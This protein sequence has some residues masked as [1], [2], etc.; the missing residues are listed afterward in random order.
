MHSFFNPKSVAV[1]GASREENKLGHIIFRNFFENGFRK[2]YP[3]NPNAEEILGVKCYKSILDVKEKIDLAIIVVPAKIVPQVLTECVKKKTP[4][5]IIISSGFSE[6]G[7]E[8]KK[9]EEQLKQIIAKSGTRVIGPNCI[10]IYD[11]YSRVDTLFLSKDRCGRPGKG[12]IS[13]IS[14]SGAVGSTI[15]DI[16][17]SSGI[18]ISKFISYGNGMDVS[19]AE[20]LEYLGKDKTTKVII[21]YIEGLKSDGRKFLE[22]AKKAKKPIIVLKSG[23]GEKGAKA[24][25]SH[26]G[27]L[28]G[29]RK[30][31][32]AA[33]KQ[34]GIIEADDWEELLDYSVAFST[35]PKPRG[36]RV[37]IITDGGGFGV[38]AAD[39][40]EELGLLLPEPSQKLKE[41]LSKRMPNYVSLHNPIDLTG[42]A[43][44]ERY[45]IA[46]NECLS[47]K[48]YDGAIVIT[49]FQVPTLEEKVVDYII[50]ARKFKK[51]LLVCSVGSNFTQ[52]RNQKLIK[53]GIPVYP[54][55]ERAVKAFHA[56]TKA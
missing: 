32:S 22:K 42:D 14:Q 24:V 49:L 12:N 10:G 3:I 18:G 29:E 35:Q 39:K 31:Y 47:S 30:I 48:E 2:L 37:V 16:F 6:I 23:K 8:G 1:I 34:F 4:S 28:A 25:S 40:A 9:I 7:D 13:F 43:N 15:L 38:L 46:L 50:E 21:A 27:S 17:Y 45:S 55:P 51:P 36:K 11:A 56:L 33:F 5:V 41:K 54:T 26:T 44:A 52:A 19:E 20:L 53:A